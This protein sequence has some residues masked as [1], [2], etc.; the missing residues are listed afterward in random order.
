MTIQEAVVQRINE[1]CWSQKTTMYRLAET[2]GMPPS[3]IKSILSGKS[4]NPGIVNLW[5]ISVGLEI[6][7]PEFFKSKI[8][9]DLDEWK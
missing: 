9:E 3:T 8:F 6:S 2:T 1:L 4:M 5:R 7:I